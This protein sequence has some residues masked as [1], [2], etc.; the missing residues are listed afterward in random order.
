MARVR[1]MFLPA[2]G[3]RATTPA[4]H[5]EPAAS[6]FLVRPFLE[7]PKSRLV[8]TLRAAGIP[9]ADD[10][11]NRDPRFTRA[12]LRGLMP[13]LAREGLDAHRFALLA[14]RIRRA[15]AAL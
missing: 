6:V 15:E 3:A 12:R 11:S 13:A 10:P 5:S 9:C 8:A 4:R 1:P 14:Q 2:A 7:I